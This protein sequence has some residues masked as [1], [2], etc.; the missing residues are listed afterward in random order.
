MMP[1]KLT[2]A[3]SYTFPHLYFQIKEQLIPI[4]HGEE[5]KIIVSEA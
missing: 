1:H 2:L 4:D 5:D 3:F